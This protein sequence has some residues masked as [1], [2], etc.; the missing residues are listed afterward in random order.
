MLRTSTARRAGSVLSVVA[1]LLIALVLGGLSSATAVDDADSLPGSPSDTATTS[2]S[3]TAD[4]P[5]PA[6]PKVGQDG[7]ESNP[8]ATATDD[9]VTQRTY[10]IR[11]WNV[12][13]NDKCNNVTPCTVQN[14]TS[15][16]Q[17]TQRPA[18][19]TVSLTSTGAI[20]VSIPAN[21]LAGLYAIRY[22]IT[23]MSGTVTATF[24]VRAYLP[25]TPD[26]YNPAMGSKFSHAFQ[27]GSA[28]RIR[29]HTLRAINSVPAGGQIRILTWSFGSGAYRKALTAARNRGVSVQ[30]IMSSSKNGGLND[31][32]KLFKIFGGQRY[33]KSD[34][35]G[36]WIYRCARSCRGAGGTMH[37]KVFMFSQSH[38]TRWIVMSGSGNLTDFAAKGQWNQQFTYTNDKNVYDT[39]Q[40]VFAQYKLDRRRWPRLL[41]LDFPTSTPKTTYWFT[42]LNAHKPQYDFMH[43]AL[44]QVSCTGATQNGGR[45]KI[46]I[47]MYV[48]RDDRGDWMARKVRQLWNAGC[49]VRIIYAIMG[50]R[51]KAI[52][53]SPKGRGRIPMRQTI[54]VDEDHRPVWY[55]HQK[56]VAIS[57][58][59]GANPNAWD[60]YQ[61][62]FNFSDLGMRSDENM[63]KISGWSYWYP[64]NNDFNAV[65]KQPQTRAPNPNSYVLQLERIGQKG[66][67]YQFMEKD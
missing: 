29:T 67:R 43:Q 37:S 60:V 1:L 35:H 39:M 53:Y 24:Y 21:T 9:S 17:I 58:K 4:N 49:D 48:W 51:N 62:S 12:L 10:S 54:Q 38:Q 56:Y 44:S 18:G 22:A 64:Y 3:G 23:D 63:Q 30:I 41:Q 26:R 8:T 42:P 59:V 32:G 20:R 31:Y 52:L 47:A 40:K 5:P 55:L 28:Y 46:R 66:G 57:G 6:D 45:T 14:M 13:R 19:W 16:M 50:N 65:W 34:A 33:K 36:S 2:A 25:K 27:K 15:P 7:T 61:G 11:Y